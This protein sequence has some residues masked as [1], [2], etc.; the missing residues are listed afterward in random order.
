MPKKLTGL[1]AA[2]TAVA[3]VALF[4]P[5]GALACSGVSAVCVYSQQNIG[6]GGSKPINKPG[7]QPQRPVQVPQGV[8]KKLSQSH[9]PSA[10]VKALQALAQNP[11]LVQKRN[12]QAVAPGSI[13]APSA[14]GAA[15][16]IGPGPVALIAVLAASAVLLLAGTGWRGWRRRRSRLAG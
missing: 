4:A 5:A 2:L 12:L 8:T 9:A 7:S 3:A 16:D 6:P 13:T 1:F 10:Q 11:N 14:L 15:F